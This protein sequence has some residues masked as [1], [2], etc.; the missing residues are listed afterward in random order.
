MPAQEVFY[1][2]GK[3]Y[4]RFLAIIMLASS[5][6]VVIAGGLATHNS[7]GYYLG[8][9]YS[10][11][12]SILMGCSLLQMDVFKSFWLL[13]FWTTSNFIVCIVALAISSENSAFLNTLEA[14]ASYTAAGSTPCS[15]SSS[16]V[17][18]ECT[19][20]SSY[21]DEAYNCEL[22]YAVDN[23]LVIEE[24]QCSCVTNE[25]NDCYSYTRISSCVDFLDL[26][27]GQVAAAVAFLT[28]LMIANLLVIVLVLVNRCKPTLIRS[29]AEQE[30]FDALNRGPAAVALV[31]SPIIVTGTPVTVVSGNRV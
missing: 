7:A 16:S 13:M 14:C 1:I 17:S 21:F 11:V 22:S 31:H 2:S 5:V 26:T 30:E 8:G 4:F 18:V 9:V 12:L 19:G 6:A 25:N 29:Q 10:G 23:D 24:D 15:S 20:D 28:I 27:P 3:R